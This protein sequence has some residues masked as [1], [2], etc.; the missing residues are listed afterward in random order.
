MR[1]LDPDGARKP[2]RCSPIGVAGSLEY[3]VHSDVHPPI[4]VMRIMKCPNRNGSPQP[5]S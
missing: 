3:V 4:R 5:V 1:L 2:H